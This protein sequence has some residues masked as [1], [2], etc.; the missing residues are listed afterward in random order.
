M[1]K[2]D[3]IQKVLISRNRDKF[4]GF[5][6]EQQPAKEDFINACVSQSTTYADMTQYNLKD[7]RVIHVVTSEKLEQSQD[8]RYLFEDVLYQVRHQ[9][10][11]GTEYYST[12]VET[13]N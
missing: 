7:E 9:V 8:A 10:R 4:G 2:R 5:A 13:P 12:L 3:Q 11:R 1:I 6:S